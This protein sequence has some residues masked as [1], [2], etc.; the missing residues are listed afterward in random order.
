MWSH[1]GSLASLCLQA[2]GRAERKACTHT[3]EGGT[4]KCGLCRGMGDCR[5]ECSF[6]FTTELNHLKTQPTPC[7]QLGEHVTLALP[8]SDL[9]PMLRQ[10][11]I[12]Y[13]RPHCCP[14][15]TCWPGRF[16][17]A[18]GSRT[19]GSMPGSPGW[20]RLG[21]AAAHIAGTWAHTYW[22]L[23]TTAHLLCTLPATMQ[24]HRADFVLAPMCELELYRWFPL[25]QHRRTVTS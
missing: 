19:R 21:L 25:A 13:G 8:Q 20:G 11:F 22:N 18:S 12:W 14:P 24:V 2:T 7:C 15:P 4:V 6:Y 23:C 17:N 1:R 9:P 3:Q 16:L 5:A 10:V